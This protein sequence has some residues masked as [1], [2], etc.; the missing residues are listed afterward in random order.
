M[1]KR[2]FTLVELLIVVA[3][4]LIL[5]ALIVGVIISLVYQVQ[6]ARTEAIILKLDTACRT[7]RIEHAAYP[8]GNGSARSLEAYLCAPRKAYLDGRLASRSPYLEKAEFVDAWGHD[9]R[10]RS[11]GVRN[12]SGV[13]LWSPGRDGL[14]GGADDVA[15]W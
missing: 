7:Y 9:I 13:D 11:P 5:S 12:G 3:L 2:G 14:D 6:I 15:N 10:Y 4:V 1:E 8:P